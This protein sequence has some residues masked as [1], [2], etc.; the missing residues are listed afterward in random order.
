MVVYEDDTYP[1]PV[2]FHAHSI[3]T[4]A[5]G[6]G[7]MSGLLHQKSW[8]AGRC[9]RNIHPCALNRQPV[10]GPAHPAHRRC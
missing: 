4:Y 3:R 9:E 10:G 8:D 6:S 5:G 1:A 7:Q 2:G